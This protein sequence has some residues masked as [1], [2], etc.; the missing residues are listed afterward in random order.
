MKKI[1]FVT[2]NKGKFLSAKI[3]LEKFGIE[4]VQKILDFDEPRTN[5]LYEITKKKALE[6]SKIFNKPLIVVDAGFFIHSLNGFPG[7]YVNFILETIGIEG[8][9]K[10]VEGK[11]RKCEFRNV[12]G[13]WEPGIKEPILFESEVFGTISE[14]PH[15]IMKDSYW[16]PLFLIFIPKGFEKTLSQLNVE[17]YWKNKT[18][19]NS[20]FI[21]FGEWFSERDKI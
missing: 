11:E 13:Y 14:K 2:K 21:K 9:L 4:L 1:I 17:K 16:S 12:L 20:C 6:A 10:L 5:D 15:G 18:K 8:I 7:T 3:Q 19:E